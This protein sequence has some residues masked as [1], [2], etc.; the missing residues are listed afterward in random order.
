MKQKM[1]KEKAHSHKSH[2]Q[3][4]FP[5]ALQNGIYRYNGVTRKEWT[6]VGKQVSLQNTLKYNTTITILRGKEV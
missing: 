5:F 1:G 3:P 2:L 4:S 6:D